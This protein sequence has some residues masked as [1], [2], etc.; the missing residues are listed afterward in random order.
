MSFTIY[1]IE[2]L[3]NYFCYADIQVEGDKINIFEISKF[4]NE[5]RE[6]VKYYKTLKGQVGF[7]SLAYD[8]QV[9]QWL[10]DSYKSLQSMTGDELARAIYSRSQEV[11]QKAN[12]NEWPDY[13]ESNIDVKQLD[14]FKVWHYD[15]KA[16]RCS[17]KWLQYSMD[18]HNIEEMPL[19]H[20]TE[21]EDEE[22]AKNILEYCKN[23]ILSTKEFYNITIGKTR[24]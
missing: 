8:A 2:S 6:F 9:I 12:S 24:K 10:V 1:D 5:I 17:L 7:N 23:D 4:K 20:W 19:P 16:R 18:W 13:K 15:N 3:R 22:T 14:L 21:V 11:I